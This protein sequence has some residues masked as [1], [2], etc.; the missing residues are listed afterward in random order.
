MVWNNQDSFIFSNVIPRGV[1]TLLVI[2]VRL[3]IPLQVKLKN[4]IK[5]KLKLNLSSIQKLT[6]VDT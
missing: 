3:E 2:K 5:I 6:E 1:S 4:K